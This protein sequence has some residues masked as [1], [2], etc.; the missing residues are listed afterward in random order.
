MPQQGPP[1]PSGEP[2]IELD[3]QGEPAPGWRV[4]PRWQRFWTG[5]RDR[6]DATP[7][8][9]T[10]V[11]LTGQTAAISAT[12]IPTE[13]LSSG[14]YRVSVTT[15]VTTADGSSSSVTPT[16]GWTR[17]S[18]SVTQV[19]TANTLDALTGVKSDTVLIHLDGATPVT[20]ATAY[21]SGTASK[22]TYEIDVVLERVSA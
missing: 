8:R 12:S 2:I 18:T 10:S 19:M 21:A 11:S 1:P 6:I 4:N 20:Y 7:F 14:L 3:E 17:T 5:Q 13:S 15:R 9:Y 22:M 16:I